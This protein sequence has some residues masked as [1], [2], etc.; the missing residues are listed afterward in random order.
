MSSPS[1]STENGE[2]VAELGAVP[3]PGRTWDPEVTAGMELGELPLEV[4][5]DGERSP[6]DGLLDYASTTENYTLLGYTHLNVFFGIRGKQQPQDAGSSR[7]P[8]LMVKDESAMA[9]GS[10]GTSPSAHLPT[11]C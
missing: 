6:A 9:E 4:A 11:T 1:M 2:Y 5:W 3:L 7:M 10:S 8:R